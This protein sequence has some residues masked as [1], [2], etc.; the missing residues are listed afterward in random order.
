MD[1]KDIEARIAKFKQCLG[2]E[3][4]ASV[5]YVEQTL[6]W[7]KENDCSEVREAFSEFADSF[8]TESEA[9]VKSIRQELDGDSYSLLPLSYIARRY[10][11]KSAAWLQ[12]R[13]NG[14][15]VRGKVYTL[16]DEQKK[17]FN[18]AVQDIA[19]RIGSIHFA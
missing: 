4:E 16:N 11:G 7:A 12:Q 13:V 3:D 15:K 1:K 18:D 5:N 6:A 14:Y 9:E 2:N 10:F 8:L 17:I 19:K